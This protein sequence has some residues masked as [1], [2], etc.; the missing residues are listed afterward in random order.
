MLK[1]I[2]FTGTPKNIKN[3]KYTMDNEKV[4]KSI[5]KSLN[6]LAVRTEKE[7]TEYGNT[8]KS[9]I[10]PLKDI[11]SSSS[12]YALEV[13]PQKV[14]IK[15]EDKFNRIFEIT[16][17]NKDKGLQAAQNIEVGTKSD[18]IKKIRD[19]KTIDEILKLIEEK[20]MKNFEEKVS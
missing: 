17:E 5:S 4:R 13:R 10:E 2:G 8:F 1:I 9:I 20:F 7:A 15:E 12:E 11:T 16:A 19:N 18:I 3:L 14:F 6:T